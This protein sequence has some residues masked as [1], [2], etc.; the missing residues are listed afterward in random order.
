[1][2][3]DVTSE[4]GAAGGR[5]IAGQGSDQEPCR[6]AT[7]H[8]TRARD[9]KAGVANAAIVM[10]WLWVHSL[11]PASRIIL[12]GLNRFTKGHQESLFLRDCSFIPARSEL[13]RKD[14]FG[15]CSKQ[16]GKQPNDTSTYQPDNS[17][18][19]LKLVRVVGTEAYLA[20]ITSSWTLR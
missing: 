6:F 8:T 17:T 12:L 9:D 13:S 10:Y 2:G 20:L 19:Q 3:S 16:N 14:K 5:A 4:V 1:M 11:E 18:S 15:E 7:H